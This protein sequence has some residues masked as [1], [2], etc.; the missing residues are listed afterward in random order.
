MNPPPFSIRRIE[1]KEDLGQAADLINQCFGE[2]M[3]PDGQRF[4]NFLRNLAKDQHSLLSVL[5]DP[6]RTFSPLDGFVC[7]ANGKLV[8]NISTS[9]FKKG[10]EKICFFSNVAVHPEYRLQGIAGSLVREVEEYAKKAGFSSAW[11]QVRKDNEIARHVYESLDYKARAVRTTW[12]SGKISIHDTAQS[13]DLIIR[14]RRA[15]DWPKQK[16]WLMANYPD[17]VSWQLELRL[18]EFTPKILQSISNTL[19]GRR[20]QHMSIWNGAQLNGVITWQSSFRFADPLWLAVPQDNLALVVKNVIPYMQ[21]FLMTRKPLMVNVDDGAG[22]DEF[23]QIGYE[24][25]HTLIWM[26]KKM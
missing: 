5:N 2:F 4:V 18:V 8:G 20:Y 10:Q 23:I 19:T 22:E 3:D 13:S 16:V 7:H 25:L 15:L 26:E 12:V 9:S 14:S 17:T 1:L 24:K 21:N 6:L 11:L